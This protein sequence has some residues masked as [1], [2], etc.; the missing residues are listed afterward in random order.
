MKVWS[1]VRPEIEPKNERELILPQENDVASSVCR[2]KCDFKSFSS[3]KSK[4]KSFLT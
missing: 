3:I 1:G 2:I 4:I